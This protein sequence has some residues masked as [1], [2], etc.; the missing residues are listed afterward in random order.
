MNICFNGG[1]YSDELVLGLYDGSVLALNDG[2]VLGLY[3][4]SMLGLYDGSIV[5]LIDGLIE[6]NRV[7]LEVDLLDGSKEIDTDGITVGCFVGVVDG[8]SVTGN[9]VGIT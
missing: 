6:G 5:V 8:E 1:T 3:D 9:M 7:R 2:P 4:G